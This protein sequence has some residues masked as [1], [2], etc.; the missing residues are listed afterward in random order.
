MRRW[1][2]PILLFWLA[3]TAIAA[4][5]PNS[6]HRIDANRRRLRAARSI[7]G[8]S[9][10]R[11][12]T[13][14]WFTVAWRMHSKGCQ[15]TRVQKE[16]LLLLISRLTSSDGACP[17][18][19]TRCGRR[20]RRRSH[21]IGRSSAATEDRGAA[22][23]TP[24]RRC[25][26]AGDD[27]A[28]RKSPTRCFG[29]RQSGGLAS[30]MVRVAGRCGGSTFVEV[31]LPSSVPAEL[32]VRHR[33]PPAGPTDLARSRGRHGCANTSDSARDSSG[34]SGEVNASPRSS[35]NSIARA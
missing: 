20:A 28:R 22:Y 14:N 26:D 4:L 2:V 10:S 16:K 33:R 32:G 13:T 31:S 24:G 1:W 6:P 27:A 17:S 30:P 35:A 19:E 9:S 8:R 7:G 23:G 25:A 11:N 5:L 15:R 29:S 21:R 34:K 12:G 18:R 3:R